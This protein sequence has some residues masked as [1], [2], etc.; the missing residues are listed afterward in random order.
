MT[1]RLNR[2]KLETPKS[3]KSKKTLD[4]YPCESHES[5]HN[6]DSSPKAGV[7]IFS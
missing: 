4:T 3:R 1:Q 5:S 6:Y 7:T 2:G